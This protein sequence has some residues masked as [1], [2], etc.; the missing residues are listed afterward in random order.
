MSVAVLLS[1]ISRQKLEPLILACAVAI[2]RF[3]FRSHDL[4]DLD[5]VNFALAME[6]F[7]PRIHQPPSA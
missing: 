1:M 2:S 3:A 5:L 6:R 7:D 4:Y